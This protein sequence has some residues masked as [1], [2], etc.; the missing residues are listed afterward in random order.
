MDAGQA[1]FQSVT[2]LGQV[3]FGAADLPKGGNFEI[4]Y[5][6]AYGGCDDSA[7]F[8]ASAGTL[9]V[10]GADGNGAYSCVKLEADCQFTVSGYSLSNLDAVQV[11]VVQSESGARAGGRA[12]G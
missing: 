6:A 2:F 1:A 5:C 10:I 12:E 8:G 11:C 9:A 7:D 3:V 4:C